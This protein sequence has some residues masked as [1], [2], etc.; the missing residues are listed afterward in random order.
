[1]LV[2]KFLI[3][4]GGDKPEKGEEWWG[5]LPLFSLLYTLITF[6]LCLGK[7]KF[8]FVTFLVFRSFELVMQDSH[9]SLYST[10]I[11]YHLYISDPSW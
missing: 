4:R 9:P 1:M 5:V 2:P 10:K 7:R 3:E 8:H 11:L 6:T